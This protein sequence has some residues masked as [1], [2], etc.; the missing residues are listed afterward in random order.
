M[1]V[2]NKSAFVARPAVT[3]GA[4]GAL[5]GEVVPGTC[6]RRHRDGGFWLSLSGKPKHSRIT[7]GR[8]Q[9]RPSSL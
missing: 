5:G 6:H 9:P 3:A 2:S 4:T 7:E 1:T 8:G